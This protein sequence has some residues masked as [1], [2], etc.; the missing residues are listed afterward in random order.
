MTRNGSLIG[1]RRV[2]TQEQRQNVPMSSMLN[3]QASMFFLAATELAAANKEPVQIFHCPC[4]DLPLPMSSSS[5]AHVQL[6]HCPCPDLPGTRVH[7]LDEWR[8]KLSCIHRWRSKQLKDRDQAR[9]AYRA[10]WET[11]ANRFYAP[12]DHRGNVAHY[13]AFGVCV[14]VSVSLC[15]YHALSLWLCVSDCICL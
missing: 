14:T 13:A 15:F 11:E 10:A 12:G 4:P 1:A 3:A 8:S 5:T 2:I 7:A 6:F 9:D